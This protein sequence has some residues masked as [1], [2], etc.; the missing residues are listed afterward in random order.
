[1][2]IYGSF[3]CEYCGSSNVDV[4]DVEIDEYDG[5]AWII[6]KLECNNCGKMFEYEEMIDNPEI[7]EQWKEALHI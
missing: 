6:F 4:V 3:E 5:Y 2:C 1:M 7:T